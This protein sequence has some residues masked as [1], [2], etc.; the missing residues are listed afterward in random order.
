MQN[1]ELK[2]DA[3]AYISALSHR[4]VTLN[5]AVVGVLMVVLAVCGLGGFFAYSLYQ[6]QLARAE[7]QEQRYDADRK[8][9]T[10]QLAQTKTVVAADAKAQAV[11]V[12]VV[13]DRDASADK[14]I[15]AVTA[16]GKSPVDAITD[17]NA[18]YKGTLPAQ[19]TPD[20][21]LAFP[22][23]TVQTFT[24][25]KLDRDR[26]DADL[27]ASENL[28]KLEKDKTTRLAADLTTSAATLKDAQKTIADYKHVA[29][30]S[31][32]HKFMGGVAKVGIFVG[33][34][35]LGSK[36]KGL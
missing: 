30:K 33:G 22:I 25:T 15:A 5:Y 24:A 31:G 6:K 29:E 11:I 27:G 18:A 32:F 23:P 26:L 17:L 19:I 20:A 34:V 4:N 36:V 7:A 2:Q 10:D 14:Q 35:L 8:V 13:H 12:K 3:A 16:P 28:L 9:L 21:Q 1:E